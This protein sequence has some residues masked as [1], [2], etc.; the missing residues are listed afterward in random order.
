[1]AKKDIE[2]NK[3]EERLQDEIKRDYREKDAKA[4]PKSGE[5]PY[6]SS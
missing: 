1:M 6:A 3:A 4:I 5:K 2:L